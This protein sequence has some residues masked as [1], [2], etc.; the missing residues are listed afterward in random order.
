MKKTLD[1]IVDDHYD[2][3]WWYGLDFGELRDALMELAKEVQDSA[4]TKTGEQRG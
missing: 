3:H 4:T 1:E 2:K